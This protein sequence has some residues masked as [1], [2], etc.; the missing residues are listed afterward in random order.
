MIPGFDSA[1]VMPSC[2]LEDVVY[3]GIKSMA[4]LYSSH[5]MCTCHKQILS[6]QQAPWAKLPPTSQPRLGGSGGSCSS[7]RLR[8][9]HVHL[10]HRPPA[11]QV[12][13]C[14][15]N[16]LQP[17]KA[18]RVHLQ[19]CRGVRGRQVGPGTELQNAQVMVTFHRCQANTAAC[20]ETR[21]HAQAA[22][23]QQP[24]QLLEVAAPLGGIVQQEEALERGALPQ[25]LLR[26]AW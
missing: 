25:Q 7:G 21:L 26:N 13:H 9:L 16:R 18:A 11:L 4:Q 1:C 12:L 24:R 22:A 3:K 2:A 23:L 17:H 10:A 6:L 8:Q 15:G 14:V 5:S 19:G 20:K